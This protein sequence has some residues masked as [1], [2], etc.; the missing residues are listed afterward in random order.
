MVTI[1]P[2]GKLIYEIIFKVKKSKDT[3]FEKHCHHTLS[4]VDTTKG[5]TS[6]SFSK[7]RSDEPDF[8]H[9]RVEIIFDKQESMDFYKKEIVPKLR[10][11]AKQFGEDAKVED[12]RIYEIFAYKSKQQ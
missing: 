4:Y 10:E 1:D 6:A 9:Y 12:R 3:D 2:V 7:R 5:M 8:S 11:N